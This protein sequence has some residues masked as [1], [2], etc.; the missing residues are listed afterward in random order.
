MIIDWWF[1]NGHQISTTKIDK[2]MVWIR[3]PSPISFVYDEIILWELPSMVGNRT[4][5]DLQ[6]LKA[7]CGRFACTCVEVDLTKLVVGRV[8]INGVWY[9]V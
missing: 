4:I 7:A 3:I 6:T 8:G 9:Q 1:I 5:V 2:T